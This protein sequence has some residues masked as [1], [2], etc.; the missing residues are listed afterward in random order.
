MSYSYQ[1]NL[2]NQIIQIITGAN[3]IDQYTIEIFDSLLSGFFK[4]ARK[5]KNFFRF[6]FLT[7]FFYSETFEFF[8]FFGVFCRQKNI[9][10]VRTTPLF[11][12]Y[13]DTD[14]SVQRAAP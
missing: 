8:L 5:T 1:F 11:N 7:T 12:F 2:Q 3:V 10:S 6:V 14:G 4:M 9:Q 13:P